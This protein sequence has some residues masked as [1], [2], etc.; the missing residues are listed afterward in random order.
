MVSAET[1]ITLLI[2]NH[3]RPWRGLCNL[4]HSTAQFKK[5]LIS[6]NHFHQITFEIIRRGMATNSQTGLY[7]IWEF[8]E[9]NPTLNP[10][11]LCKANKKSWHMSLSSLDTIE[12]IREEGNTMYVCSACMLKTRLQTYVSSRSTFHRV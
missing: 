11:H 3:R 10:P 9:R 4:L 8:F 12:K 7:P 5:R 1:V 6:P 2:Y